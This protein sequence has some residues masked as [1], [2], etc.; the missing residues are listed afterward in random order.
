MRAS[1]GQSVTARRASG[2]RPLGTGSP[3]TPL[4]PGE[5]IPNQNKTEKLLLVGRAMRLQGM[6]TMRDVDLL[7]QF[8]NACRD[9][10]GRLRV[11]AAVG[12]GRGRCRWRHRVGAGR[13]KRQR[14][15]EGAIGRSSG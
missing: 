14:G 4:G 6:I 12:V 1:A 5:Q 11:G 3:E 9:S 8:P 10:R 7:H 2:R 13:R 15:R